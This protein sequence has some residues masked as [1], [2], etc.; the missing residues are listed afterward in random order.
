MGRGVVLALDVPVP[1]GDPTPWLVGFTVLWVALSVLWIRRLRTADGDP[2]A[3]VPREQYLG[4]FA[5][6]GGLARHSWERAIERLPDNDGDDVEGER[7][8]RRKREE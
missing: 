2:W 5:G 4:R 1:Y 8:G 7:R 6:H 3:M